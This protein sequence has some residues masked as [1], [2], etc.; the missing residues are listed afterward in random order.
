MQREKNHCT[1]GAAIEGNIRH[2][3]IEITHLAVDTHGRFR[4]GT[5]RPQ[6]L[7]VT[8]CDIV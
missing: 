3:E 5:R 2:E 8:R 1:D 4:D 6:Q 7:S